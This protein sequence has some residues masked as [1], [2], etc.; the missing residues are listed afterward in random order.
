[1]PEIQSSCKPKQDKDVK[2]WT[3]S[4][5]QPTRAKKSVSNF[6]RPPIAPIPSTPKHQPHNVGNLLFIKDIGTSWS[7]M[8]G[9]YLNDI[10]NDHCHFSGGVIFAQHAAH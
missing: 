4:F 7:F 6:L 3:C 10:L 2:L 9:P 5:V 8:L 1:M